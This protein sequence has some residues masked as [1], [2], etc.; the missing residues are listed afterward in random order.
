M[1]ILFISLSIALLSLTAVAQ[2]N[3][4][5]NA[6][7]TDNATLTFG[8]EEKTTFKIDTLRIASGKSYLILIDV[9]KEYDDPTVS[10]MGGPV[11][12]EEKE[13]LKNFEEDSFEI[14][15][16]YQHTLILFENGQKLDLSSLAN[17]FQ[18][19][20]YWNGNIEDDVQFKNIIKKS[21]EFVAEQMGLN[22][23]SS[24]V[25]NNEKYKEALALLQNKNNF[26]EKSRLIMNSFL[27]DVYKAFLNNR[28]GQ[29]ANL[30]NTLP[31]NL[32]KM[33]L[34]VSI[35]SE[36]K[37]LKRS[38]EINKK[39]QIDKLILFDRAGKISR[40]IQYIYE[41]DIL[42][43]T[44]NDQGTTTI[45]SYDD[46]KMISFQ[47]IGDANETNV[48]YLKN[49]KKN[50]ENYIIMIDDTYA[51]QNSLS[52]TINEKNCEIRYINNVVWTRNCFTDQNVFPYLHTYTS[53]QDGEVLQYRK[54][55]I[56]KKNKKTYHKYY[57]NAQQDTDK[58]M[59]ELKGIYQLNDD[60]LVTNYTITD[61]E[62]KVNL[63]I[64]YIYNH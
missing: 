47:N 32:K 14:I 1:K 23:Q 4:K 11:D 42:K 13:L 53:Y 3:P 6:A 29:D 62:E 31:E 54:F 38:I 9:Q 58:D 18:G 26:T 49:D 48:Y 44:I 30:F 15:K 39:G 8:S 35:G 16:Q 25:I 55:K 22:T 34:S 20:A 46:D 59:Y 41:N 7:S 19:V 24:Y 2:D 12:D 64:E 50:I 17:T 56:E 40:S 36:E 33:N 61:D 5:Q 60:N 10:I 45:F 28:L 52:K 27:D 63:E 51:S 57:S 43:K 37:M 21:T